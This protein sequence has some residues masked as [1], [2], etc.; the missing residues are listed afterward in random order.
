MPGFPSGRVSGMVS[1]MRQVV[2]PRVRFLIA[3]RWLGTRGTP[4]SAIVVGAA[5]SWDILRRAVPSGCGVDLSTLSDG[6]TPAEH[7]PA[8]PQLETLRYLLPRRGD[9][10]IFS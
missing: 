8:S 7:L 1:R 9:C 4:V 2:E 5:H 6:T 3:E 10:S